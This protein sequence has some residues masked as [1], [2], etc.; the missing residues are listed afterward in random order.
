PCSEKVTKLG[1]YA[2]PK[3]KNIEAL[4]IALDYYHWELKHYQFEKNPIWEKYQSIAYKIASKTVKV[5]YIENF[6][7]ILP[8]DEKN[9]FIFYLT[10][11]DNKWY[12]TILDFYT[13]DC[14]A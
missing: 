13:M 11:L 9:I 1:L 2:N 5:V 12:L 3:E 4:K 6:A 7:G 8:N 10:Q 14:S